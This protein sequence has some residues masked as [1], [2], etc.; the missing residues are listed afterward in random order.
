MNQLFPIPDV[1]WF[2]DSRMTL[3]KQLAGPAMLQPQS[4]GKKGHDCDS[5]NWK[6][7]TAKSQYFT[8]S[9]C[10]RDSARHCR[11]VSHNLMNGTT[12]T[13]NWHPSLASM[14][15]FQ[16][17]TLALTLKSRTKWN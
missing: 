5:Y 12:H 11:T 15:T 8:T 16:N 6:I 17:V 13:W 3:V 10:H 14:I 4:Q 7:N 9:K 2:P 1:V